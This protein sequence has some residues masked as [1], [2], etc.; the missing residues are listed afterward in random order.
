M[1]ENLP[2]EQFSSTSGNPLQKRISLLSEKGFLWREIAELAQ[3]PKKLIKGIAKGEYVASDEESNRMCRALDETIDRLQANI[4][5]D[6]VS[7]LDE[8]E[9]DTDNSQWIKLHV[10]NVSIFKGTDDDKMIIKVHAIK[11]PSKD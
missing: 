10:K 5:T 1:K 11:L 6:P 4:N 3:L 9:N 8:S 7:I 2:V